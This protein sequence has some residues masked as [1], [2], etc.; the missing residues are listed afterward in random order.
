MKTIQTIQAMLTSIAMLLFFSCSDK[1][2]SLYKSAPGPLLIFSKDTITVREKDFSNINATNNGVCW[3][4]S[5]PAIHQLN[6]QYNDTSGKVHFTYRGQVMEQ[7]QPIIVAGDSTSLFCS[8]DEA[9]VY[10]I[11]FFLTD[12]LGKTTG[13]QLIVN[14]LVNQK[15]KAGLNWQLI[16]SSQTDNWV[17]QFDASS[18]YKTDGIITGYHY[19]INNQ[20]FI[21]TQALLNWT[22]HQRGEQTISLFVI[23][24]LDQ[25]S[26]TLHKKIIIP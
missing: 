6:I 12:Q 15:T 13:R 3:L 2:A 1:Y 22:F 17:Y 7:S 18:C 9:G 11:D 21:T 4:H 8:C 26:D 10:S 20:S 25:S 19:S 16:D 24:D 14:C 23:D 5:I